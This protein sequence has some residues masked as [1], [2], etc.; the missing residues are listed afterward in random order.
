[1]LSWDDF[2]YVKAIAETRSLGGAAAALG[3]NHST[4]FRRLAQVEQRLGSRLF[5]RSRNGYSLTASGEEMVQLAGRMNDEI[6]AFERKV[7]GQDLRPSGELRITTSDTL[8]VHLL[9]DTLA[10]FRRTYPEI[11]LD[12]VLA[13][14]ALN[15]SKRDADIALRATNRPPE[16][17]IGRRVATIAWAIYGSAAFATRGFDPLNDVRR[18]DWVGFGDGLSGL[19]AAKWLEQHVDARRVVYKVNTV[20]GLAEAAGAGIGLTLLPC[21]IGAVSPGLA[22]LSPPD[23]S[24]DAS[25][26]LLTHPD[27]RQTARVHAFM[28]YV[29]GDLSRRR[30]VIEGLA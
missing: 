18:H 28:E 6:V 22:R 23:P 26:W 12:V 13:N 11:M 2:R 9:P 10:G 27:L 20:L 17:L 15:L 5:E 4:V 3:L 25:L 19:R 21:F 16:S 8:L 1:M 7:T 29:A 14:Q 24:L 30:K